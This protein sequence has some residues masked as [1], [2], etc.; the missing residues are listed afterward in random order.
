MLDVAS[1]SCLDDGNPLLCAADVARGV[2]RMLLR[3]DLVTLPEVPL[4]GGRRA[5]L[6]AIDAR[7]G[8]VVVE[9][10]VSRADLLGDG[11]WPDYLAHCDR[12]FWAVPAGFDLSPLDGPA[13]LP[14][15]TGV[16]VAD[17]YDAEIV[18]QAHTVPLPAHVRKRC[19]LAFA[20]R[21]ARRLTALADPEA[22]AL[23]FE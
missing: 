9:I 20:R 12:Y 22:A 5:D 23:P 14:E 1:S 10:K 13:F 11:K 18:R 3:H 4:D 6:M 21:A 15:R 8:L 2:T 16:I 17:R 19:T 7:G